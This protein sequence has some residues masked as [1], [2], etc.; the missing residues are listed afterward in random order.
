MGQEK[1]MGL[2]FAIK[3]LKMF[4]FKSHKIVAKFVLYINFHNLVKAVAVY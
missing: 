2:L 3:I 4:S 1:N